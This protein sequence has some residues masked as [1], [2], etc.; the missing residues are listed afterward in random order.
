M[1]KQGSL[2]TIVDHINTIWP[3][4]ESLLLV[5]D[6]VKGTD[7]SITGCCDF[8]FEIGVGGKIFRSQPVVLCVMKYIFICITW[9]F[10]I[11]IPIKLYIDGTEV[12]SLTDC[13]D[14]LVITHS[15]TSY[16]IIQDG[17]PDDLLNNWKNWR[18]ELFKRPIKQS[19]NRVLKQLDEQFE[20][21]RLCILSL[22]AHLNNF[23]SNPKLLL[24]NILPILRSLLFWNDRK[25]YNPLLFRLAGYL[26]QDMYL[27]ALS[28]E[29]RRNLVNINDIENQFTHLDLVSLQK[30]SPYQELTDFQEWLISKVIFERS[31]YSYLDLVGYAANTMSFAHFDV[32]TYVIL[33]D[34]IDKK[35][36]KTSIFMDIIIQITN[37]SILFGQELLRK[38][39]E[40]VENENLIKY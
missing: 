36:L 39:D 17:V 40:K 32:N 38:Y 30:K 27:Y 29:T 4:R 35:I 37:F 31:E 25:T 11:D 14:R 22:N 10:D 12:K 13:K 21:L 24:F 20:E 16:N 3:F 1:Q 15:P 28:E 33:I 26:N 23:S 19:E 6:K 9:D 2:T 34:L 8:T 7:I 5:E 18:N